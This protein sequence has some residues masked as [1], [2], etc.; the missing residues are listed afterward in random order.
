MTYRTFVLF[1]VCW[2][3]FCS[4]FLDFPLL[5]LPLGGA[6]I[7]FICTWQAII[8]FGF[9]GLLCKVFQYREIHKPEGLYLRRWYL[10]PRVRWLPFQIFLHNIRLDDSRDFHDHPW[11]FI[12]IILRGSYREF[13][14]CP[15]CVLNGW[16]LHTEQRIARAG[17]VLVNTAEHTHRVEIIKPVWSLVIARRPRRVW[18]FWTDSVD[19][20]GLPISKWTDWRTFLGCKGAEDWPEDRV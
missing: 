17:S 12:S 14:R 7:A 10:S 8:D 13:I 9:S 15:S 6:W 20:N 18:G 1:S 19:Q 11:P 4:V 5:A 3:L 16:Y 2:L